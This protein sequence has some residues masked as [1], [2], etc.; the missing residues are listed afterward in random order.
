MGGT[1][2]RNRRRSRRRSARRLGRATRQSSIPAPARVARRAGA[3]RLLLRI[4]QT[5][6]SGRCAT[7]PMS[8]RCSDPTISIPIAP[9]T[10]DSPMLC[11]KRRRAARRWC[12]SQ[13]YHFALAPKMIHERLPLSTIVAFWHIPWPSP[14]DFEICPWAP[15]LLQG[16]LGSS[17]VGFQTPS[18]CRNFIETVEPPSRHTSIASTA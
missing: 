15:Q 5:R 4:L 8:S 13:D 1:R 17:V 3:A 7:A 2:R 10:P 11:V 16:L 9:S 14:R 12:W 18:D 6:G